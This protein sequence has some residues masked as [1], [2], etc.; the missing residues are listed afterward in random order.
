MNTHYIPRLLLRQFSAREKINTYD[1]LTKS[2]CTK[3][4]KNCFSEKDLFDEDL[5]RLFA[6][7]L[8]GLMG[9]LLNHKLLNADKIQIN[10]DENLLLRKF[11][12]I[13]SLRAPIVNG[14]WEEMIERTKLANHPSAQARDFLIRHDSKLK[15]IFERNIPSVATYQKDLKQAMEYNSIEELANPDNIH[16]VSKTLRMAASHALISTIAFWDSEESGQEFILPK[17]PGISMMDKV[18]IFHKGLVI[19]VKKEELK[20]KISDSIW[21]KEL[22]RL[23][24]GSIVYSDNFTIYPISP[25]RVLVCFSPYFRAF[26]PIS[27]KDGANRTLQ[28]PPLLEKEQ[29]ERHFFEPMR[30]ELFEPCE[31]FENRFYQYRVRSLTSQEVM[32]L[33]SLLLDMETEEFAFHDLHKI[34]G[35]L[36]YYDNYAVFIDKKKHD[37]SKLYK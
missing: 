11:L 28:F 17:L 19:K 5:E 23:E 32:S 10:R 30:M 33:N 6:S 29:F 13:N 3:K 15:E 37:F 16:N 27:I 9:D 26:F 18:N 25:T 1:F 7:R 34:C 2:F 14:T 20:K 31:S 24:Y 12:M 4:L 22:D 21:A 8:E 35:S 36:K